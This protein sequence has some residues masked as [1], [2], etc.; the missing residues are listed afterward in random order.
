MSN[1][2][3]FG[4]SDLFQMLSPGVIV[5]KLISETDCIFLNSLLLREIPPVYHNVLPEWHRFLLEECF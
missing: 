3:F 1:Y 5:E 4:Q 2:D